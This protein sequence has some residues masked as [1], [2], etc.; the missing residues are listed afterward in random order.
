M[1]KHVQCHFKLIFDI[2]WLWWET[3]SWILWTEESIWDIWK[4]SAIFNNFINN[5]N[6]EKQKMWKQVYLFNIQN[7]AYGFWCGL[8]WNFVTLGE[9][10]QGIHSKTCKLRTSG[11]LF[12]LETVNLRYMFYLYVNFTPQYKI[13][14]ETFMFTQTAWLETLCC[15]N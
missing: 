11:I 3:V 5:V 7:D 13:S 1:L 15:L 6:I 4:K 12:L 9:F 14:S 2:S 8:W 10:T